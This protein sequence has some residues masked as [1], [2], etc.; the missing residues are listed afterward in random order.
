[1]LFVIIMIKRR[2]DNMRKIGY[3]ENY[4]QNVDM[5]MLLLVY[6]KMER[7]SYKLY[8]TISKFYVYKF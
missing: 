5:D 3:V 1:M 4:Y 6:M 2:L 7:R 8:L